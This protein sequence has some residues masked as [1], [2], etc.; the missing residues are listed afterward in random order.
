LAPPR[1]G[2]RPPAAVTAHLHAPVAAGAAELETEVVRAGRSA[3]SV[4]AAVHQETLR[5]S[6]LVLLDGDPDSAPANRLPLLGDPIPATPPEEAEPVSPRADMSLPVADQVEIRP[7]GETRP[8]AG[9]DSPVLRAWIRPRRPIADPAA[10][11]AI[12]LDALA[13][14]LFAVRTEPIAIPTIELSMHLAPPRPL[15]PWSAISQRTVWSNGTF[16]VDEADLRNED[17][18]LIAQARQRRRILS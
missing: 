13:P 12:L 10:R 15:T 16:C 14:S 8:L 17:G 2:E 18:T 9:G 1:A 7:T 6:A 5:A 11:A 3:A 4:R